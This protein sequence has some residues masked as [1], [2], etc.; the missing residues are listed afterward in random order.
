MVTA[1][2]SEVAD[3]WQFLFTHADSEK[4]SEEQFYQWKKQCRKNAKEWV[5]NEEPP[6]LKTSVEQ[7]TKVDGETTSFSMVGF[8]ANARIQVVQDVNL[9]LKN[10]NWKFKPTLWWRATD[11]G[12][13]IKALQS[14]CRSHKPQG[15]PIVTEILLVASKT[16]KFLHKA[17]CWWY[18]P[19][20][21]REFGRHPGLTKTEIAYTHRY[22]YHNKGQTIWKWVMPCEQDIREWRLDHR[23]THLPLQNPSEHV[24]GNEDAMLTD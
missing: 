5:A 7:F 6:S 24:T 18:A 2:F 9:I 4:E 15:W 16:A 21:H 23:L 22:C 14:R 8:R 1:S 11:I 17:A 13:T 19:R 3:E 12:W 20:S 10:L